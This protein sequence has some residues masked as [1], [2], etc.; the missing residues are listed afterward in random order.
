LADFPAKSADFA[1]LERN[2]QLRSTAEEGIWLFRGPYINNAEF[3]L[4]R[5]KRFKKTN[6]ITP[7]IPEWQRPE[8]GETP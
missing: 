4:S 1:T 8:S 6:Q 7:R 3:L 2:K 5:I